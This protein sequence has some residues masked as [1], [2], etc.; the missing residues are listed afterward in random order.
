MQK[1]VGLRQLTKSKAPL[2]EI[3]L[4]V[5][6]IG[7]WLGLSVSLGSAIFWGTIVAGITLY[8]LL[9]EVVN[10]PHHL[11]LENSEKGPAIPAWEQEP[12]ARSCLYPRW[13][14]ELVVLN[15]N[16]HVEHHLFPDVPW[17]DLPR[18][19]QKLVPDLGPNYKTDPGFEWILTNRKRNLDSVLVLSAVADSKAA[20]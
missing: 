3:F 17:Y 19:S 2:P 20:A 11:Q 7:F 14:S 5:L 1:Q 12:Y 10:F 9:V 16:Y 18:L 13:I 6:P 4:A 8:L 15:F